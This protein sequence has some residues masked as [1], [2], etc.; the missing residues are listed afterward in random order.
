MKPRLLAIRNR[1]RHRRRGETV[2]IWPVRQLEQ[3]SATKF[4][5]IDQRNHPPSFFDSP[6]LPM[7]GRD[8]PEAQRWAG[9]VGPVQAYVIVDI[10]YMR[11][12]HP[13]LENAVNQ[14]NRT[15]NRKPITRVNY[16]AVTPDYRA[17]AQPRQVVAGLPTASIR[18]RVRIASP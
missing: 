6:A 2:A 13:V 8:E 15:K 11:G 1:T 18:E 3:R 4:E 10:E 17:A 5:V 12:Y 14:T 7:S 9:V 16:G